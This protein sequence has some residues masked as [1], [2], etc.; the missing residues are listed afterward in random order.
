MNRIE[1]LEK[2]NVALSI[3]KSELIEKVWALESEIDRL[4]KF[5]EFTKCYYT[6]FLKERRENESRRLSANSQLF[7]YAHA[8]RLLG[9]PNGAPLEGD[10][11]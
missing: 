9:E 6:Q 5:E 7:I 10:T 8:N 2:E 11:K 3:H 4:R 1:F